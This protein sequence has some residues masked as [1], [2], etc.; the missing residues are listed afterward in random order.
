MTFEAVPPGTE[1][2]MSRPTAS[3]GL[4]PKTLATMTAPSGMITNC[5][6]TP[7]STGVGRRAISLKS[8]MVKVR[9]MPNMMIMRKYV[10]YC[11][12]G[13]NG[14]G[15]AKAMAAPMRINTGNAATATAAERSFMSPPF[16]NMKTC[17]PKY[18]ME[19]M[20]P[21][22]LKRATAP[23]QQRRAGRGGQ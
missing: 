13:R 20:V 23:P 5:A 14:A 3:I 2:S 6:T 7:T 17:V 11:F 22:A 16:Q 8:G 9:P 19:G 1:P 18:G 15:A 4:S 21:H 12:S 10:M